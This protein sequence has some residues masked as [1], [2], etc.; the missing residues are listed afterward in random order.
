MDDNNNYNGINNTN[1]DH[2]NNNVNNSNIN[3]NNNS[4]GVYN[5]SNINSNN[6]QNGIYSNSSNNS[7]GIYNNSN[8]NSN[9]IQNGIYNNSN[10]NPNGI[11]SNSNI[12]SNNNQNGIYDDFA[13][14]NFSND[15]S[16][17]EQRQEQ[18]Q[19]MQQEQKIKSKE[20]FKKKSLLAIVSLAI[21]VII[22]AIVGLFMYKKIQANKKSE[23]ERL[24]QN[25]STEQNTKPKL[26]TG[27][28][29][30]NKVKVDTTKVYDSIEELLNNQTNTPIQGVLVGVDS[31]NQAY[32]LSAE[33]LGWEVLTDNGDIVDLIAIKSTE[34]KITLSRAA[35]YNNGVKAL[36]EICNSLYGDA[37][38]NGT[39]AISARSS[40]IGDFFSDG[41][42]YT[43]SS[44]DVN[45]IYPVIL[46]DDNTDYR[47]GWSSQTNYYTMP[48]AQQSKSAEGTLR[49]K[50]NQYKGESNINSKVITTGN[51]YWLSSRCVYGG[52]DTC[53]FGLGAI[54]ETGIISYWPTYSSD[55]RVASP[56]IGIRP[57]IRVSRELLN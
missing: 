36:D 10:N 47:T 30:S 7:N 1:R 8:I 28:D 55:G 54:N 44:Y 40:K 29:V 57:V 14:N 41:R 27:T 23:A 31:N 20:S 43:E 56:S 39:K 12:N 13:P 21:I 4:D 32:K 45:N 3:S 16:L 11:Y 17:Y 34:L 50:T 48:K 24:N 2:N 15:F 25:A 22:V 53:N 6:N 19:R 51:Q 42:I 46:D 18:Q 49:I 26:A 9:N 52:V 33:D 38:I 5:N 37:T 35:G